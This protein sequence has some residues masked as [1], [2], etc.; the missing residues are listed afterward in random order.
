MPF[1]SLKIEASLKQDE[2]LTQ[3]KPVFFHL[4]L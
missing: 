4:F 1:M 3:M 2:I